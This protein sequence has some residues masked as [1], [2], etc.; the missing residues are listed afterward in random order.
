MTYSSVKD[1]ESGQWRGRFPYNEIISLLD[2]N[3]PFNLAE[4]TSQDLTVGELLDFAGSRTFE[5]ETRLCTSA[6]AAALREEIARACKIPADDVITTQGTAL[7][8]FLLAFE[9]CRPGD[10]AVL[11]TPCSTK[12]RQPAWCRRQRPR[13]QVVVR[14]RLS[15][16]PGPDRCKPFAE[17]EAREHCVAPKS[18]WGSDVSSSC[19]DASPIAGASV[20]G[21]HS[22]HRRDLSRRRLT[23]M[24]S[25]PAALPGS[26]RV[27]SRARRYRRRLARRG[28][29]RAGSR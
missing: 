28:C 14:E 13:G 22:L 10:E 6:G 24:K 5:L 1:P 16:R 11:V 29:G 23:A 18:K 7:G 15:V 9:I 25:R 17:D 26:I 19:R 21:S 8:L 27:S 4:S 12:P 2:V 3:R 20:S